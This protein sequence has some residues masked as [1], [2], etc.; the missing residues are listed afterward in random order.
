M[1]EDDWDEFNISHPTPF[2]RVDF[3][4]TAHVVL[5]HIATRNALAFQGIWTHL[6]LRKLRNSKYNSICTKSKS[7]LVKLV[8][9][10]V[11]LN[12]SLQQSHLVDYLLEFIH[13]I[14]KL[15]PCLQISSVL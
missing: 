12:I 2:S 4:R 3:L 1:S 13:S 7:G 8:I 6:K 9:V 5:L 14:K 10:R 11:Q 15:T